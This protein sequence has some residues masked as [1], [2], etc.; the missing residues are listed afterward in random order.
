MNVF[1]RK[2]NNKTVIFVKNNEAY[3]FVKQNILAVYLIDAEVR[4]GH[5]FV[6]YLT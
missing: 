5:I 1:K 6:M 3:Y 2:A 4:A